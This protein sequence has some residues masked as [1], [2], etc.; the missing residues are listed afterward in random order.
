MMSNTR[1]RTNNTMNDKRRD[2]QGKTWSPSA[3]ILFSSCPLSVNRQY[4]DNDMK[5][6]GENAVN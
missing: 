4:A 2:R 5:N 6:G 1:T 3:I